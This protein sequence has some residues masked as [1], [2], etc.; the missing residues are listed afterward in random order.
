MINNIDDKNNKNRTVAH[1]FFLAIS[2]SIAEPSTILPLMVSHF[3]G[4]T[5]LVGIFAALL[6]GGAILVQMVAAFYAQ[7]FTLVMPYIKRVFLTRFLS[8]F[9]IGIIIFLIG[10]KNKSITLSLI[11]LGLFIFSFS[12]GF[13]A[14]YF[15]ELLGKMFSHKYRGKV[16]ATRQFFAGLG[17]IMSGAVAGWVL[18]HFEAPISY[19]YLFLVSGLLMAIGFIIFARCEEPIKEKVTQKEESF[20]KFIKKSFSLL[21]NEKNLQYQILTY[22]LSYSYLFSLPF[23][24]LDAKEKIHLDGT[25]IGLFISAQMLGATLS[26]LLWGKLSGSGKNRLIVQISTMV[27]FVIFTTLIFFSN[28]YIYIAVFF[29]IG[30]ALDG[31]RLAFTNLLLII[32]PEDKR[33]IYVALQANIGSIGIFFSIIGGLILKFSNYESLYILTTCLMFLTFFISFKLKD[34]SK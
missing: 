32:A 28:L 17:A 30:M 2:T 11:G 34:A 6:R 24:I 25:A 20:L 22:L 9:G 23:I 12:A 31:F 21:K 18:N 13:G 5:V 15:R 16:M 10:D 26:N 3:G 14:I 4:G 8:W 1:G 27:M 33:P 7:S 19:A 29:L